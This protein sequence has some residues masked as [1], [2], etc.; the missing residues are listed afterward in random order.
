MEEFPGNNPQ[1]AKRQTERPEKKVEKVVTG[2]VTLRKKPMG[3]KFAETFFGGSAKEAGSAMVWQVLLP[4]T[5]EMIADAT[6]SYIQQMLFGDHARVINKGKPEPGRVNY[7]AS[8]KAASAHPAMQDPRVL[9]RRA[10]ASHDFS[11]VVLESRSEAQG[12]LDGLYALL[13]QYHV[14][15]VADLYDL[16]GVSV[17]GDYTADNWGWTSLQGS[18]IAYAAGRY[19]LD[20]PNPEELPK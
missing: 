7:G 9:S 12:V 17:N 5:K 16:I 11:E 18:G 8:Y 20:L 1:K 14:V 6:T 13:S 15:S 19:L 2:E 4:K 10:R 3:K